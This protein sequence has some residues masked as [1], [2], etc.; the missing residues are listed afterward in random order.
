MIENKTINKKNG[1]NKII[2][3]TSI[4]KYYLNPYKYKYKNV[5]DDDLE[6]S[7]NNIDSIIKSLTSII[8]SKNYEK[9]FLKKISSESYINNKLDFKEN[10][11]LKLDIEDNNLLFK[12]IANNKINELKT[13]INH[14]NINLNIQDNDGDTPLHIAIF[15]CNYKACEL[16]ILNK[17]NINIKDKYGQISLHRLCFCLDDK[18]IFKIINLFIKFINQSKLINIFD[19][20]DN[21]GNTPLHLVVKYLIKN[22]INLNDNHINIIN[23]LKLFTNTTIKNKDGNTI[24]KLLEMINFYFL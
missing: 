13:I 15:L 22:K 20:V 19:E 5:F 16:L 2:I 10:N 9:T 1:L 11:K 24:E 21:N 23:K 6:L 3:D 12:L 4:D 18:N 8:I 17:A 14:K 7:E